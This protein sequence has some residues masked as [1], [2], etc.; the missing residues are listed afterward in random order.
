MRFINDSQYKIFKSTGWAQTAQ[1]HT[2]NGRHL[3]KDRV[4][5]EI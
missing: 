2:T 1:Q 5:T 3:Y 4:Y